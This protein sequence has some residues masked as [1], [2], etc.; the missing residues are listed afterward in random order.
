MTRSVS[1]LYAKLLRNRSLGL[2]IVFLLLQGAGLAQSSRSRI[3]EV[4]SLQRVSLKGS[5]H[6]LAQ[7]QFLA[8]HAEASAQLTGVTL[9]FKPSDAQQAA[10][11]TLLAAQ[12]NPSS[13]QYRKWLTPAQY[14]SRFG[15]TA[16]DTG[17]VAQWLSA[18]GLTVN[19]I[20]PLQVSFS[21]DVAHLESAFQTTINR[22]QINGE[23]HLAN[24]SEISLPSAIAGVT[25][26]V[27]NLAE[28]RPRP[29]MRLKP[30]YTSSVSGAHYLAPNDFDT[31][32]DVTPLYNAGYTGTGE[33]IVVVGQSAILATDVSAF[34]TASGLAAKAPTLTLVPG[35]GTS[36]TSADDEQESDLDVEW[37]GAIAQNATIQFVYVGNNQ[38]YGVFDSLEYAVDEDLAPVVSISYGECEADASSDVA[39]LT[40]IFE[41]ANAQGQTIVAASGDSGAADCDDGTSNN[42]VVTSA[43]QG[44]AVDVPAASPLVTGIGGTE[45]LG[46]VAAPSTYWNS[47]N[48]SSSGSVISYI[49]EE[50]WNDTSTANGLSASG[51]GKSTLFSK[52]SW[53]TGTG[54]PADGQR[55]VPDLA[56]AASPD[57]DGYLFCNEG[58]CSNGFRDSSQNL[59]V[60]GGTSFGAPT[61]S[62]LLTLINQKLGLTT[63]GQGNINPTIYA[64]AASTPASFHDITTGNNEVPC[65]AGT[66]D[67]GSSGTLGFVAGT[68]YDQ[69]TGW[70]SVDAYAL[71]NA[72]EATSVTTPTTVST[73][74]SLTASPMAPVINTAVTFT[75]V[76]SPSSGTTAPTGTIQFSIDGTNVGTAAT[77]TA[78]SGSTA[79]VEAAYAYAG[80]AASGSHTVTAVYSGDSTHAASTGI[81]TITVAATSSGTASFALTGSS[82]N[83]AQG[84]SGTSTIT[85]TPAGGYTGTVALTVTGPS[86]L[87]NA[88]YT[89]GS[90][91]VTGLTPASATLTVNTTS[92]ACAV[93]G[94]RHIAVASLSGPSPSGGRNGRL[95]GE[96][97]LA[98]ALLPCVGLRRRGRG[99]GRGRR[100][101][102][103]FAAGLAVLLA[104]GFLALS[105]C[106]SS[107]TTTTSAEAPKGTYTL[108]VT[109]TDA[110]A[111][112]TADTTVTL[113][114][115]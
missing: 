68:G 103:G 93:A 36:A 57:H 90:A 113:T 40:S 58:S 30:R 18:Q 89:V 16:A 23:E 105:G 38:N 3:G 39:T 82:I 14:A 60:A 115:N 6:P 80:F 28:F 98:L 46:D 78:V 69:V 99:P 51:G 88:C 59:T 79:S 65:T 94:A 106:G 49:P 71:A 114:I 91:N 2:V 102:V 20:T 19:K 5:A 24:A 7:A 41:Q 77:V 52:P 29:R 84:S 74:T 43:K 45:F 55:D 56:L 67:C 72:F 25:L 42:A 12:R 13:P 11:D 73:T 66:T 22:Y 4:D 110:T 87:T 70:G 86:T 63:T 85:V 81:L 10:L 31:I 1:R 54:V 108:T 75:A 26:G 97:F 21:G 100:V 15:L 37:S 17:K 53:Q 32:Y 50:A 44:L 35:T 96:A 64:I 104:T 34:R 76:V 61:F 83:V 111:N 47:S 109:G 48:N 9:H 27:R 112:L 95:P 62:A 92:S 33:T 8:G 101:S 107:S